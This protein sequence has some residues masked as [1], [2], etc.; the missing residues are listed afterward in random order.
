MSDFSKILDE[1]AGVIADRKANPREGSY[2]AKLF[3][4]GTDRILKKVGEEAGEVIIA[5]KNGAPAEIVHEAS[6]LLY[7]LLVLLAHHDIPLS[8]IARELERRRG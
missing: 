1:L 8:D 5:S 4:G 3:S 6:D 2:T 7:H